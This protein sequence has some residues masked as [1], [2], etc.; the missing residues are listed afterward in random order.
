V[1]HEFDRVV[2][3]GGKGLDV[4]GNVDHEGASV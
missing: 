2:A 3:E 4:F 1:L